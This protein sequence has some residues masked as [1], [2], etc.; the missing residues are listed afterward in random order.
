MKDLHEVW[1]YG[2]LYYHIVL[3]NVCFLGGGGGAGGLC[4][5]FCFFLFI[6]P[7]SIMSPHLQ[8]GDI[9]FGADLVGGAGFGVTLSC[10]HN[11]FRTSGYILTKFSWIYNW[12]PDKGLVGF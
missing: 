4:F 3:D 5:F 9:D 1:Y 10:L 12:E 7:K 2:N 6:Q 11:I 8:E